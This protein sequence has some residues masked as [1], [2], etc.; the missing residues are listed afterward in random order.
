MRALYR[1]LTLPF[2]LR[3]RDLLASAA[4][5]LATGAAAHAGIIS[6]RLPWLP[7]AGD[8]PPPVRPGPWQFFTADEARAAEALVDRLI[9]PDPDTPGGKDA[10]C[11][12]YLDR[13]MAGPYGHGDGLYNRPP[14]MTGTP[15][16]GSQSK[17]SLA[18]QYRKGLNAIDAYCRANMSGK[19]FAELSDDD[20][21]KLLKGLESGDV[22]L[23]GIDGKKFFAQLL[24]DTQQGFFAD[25][26]YGG[27][28]DMVSWKMIG[29]PG[30]RYNYLDWI[31][32]H[33]QPYPLPPV[34]LAGRIDWT[35][36]R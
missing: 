16:Q 24:K 35:P 11:A 6:G 30:A 1:F 26:V 10:G 32:K 22:K 20:K 8:P 25:P 23:D 34:S 7:N 17:D 28:R 13:Q 12:I 19:A 18:A 29:F 15:Q 4:W 27:N 2:M 9:P 36:K 5:L 31:E 21:D 14:F 3:R 33:N